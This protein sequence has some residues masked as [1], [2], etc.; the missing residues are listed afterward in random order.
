MYFYILAH[1]A[2]GGIIL[3]LYDMTWNTDI[4]AEQQIPIGNLFKIQIYQAF[5]HFKKTFTS[6]CWQVLNVIGYHLLLKTT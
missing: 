3:K 4:N 2:M 5:F 1:K 6:I